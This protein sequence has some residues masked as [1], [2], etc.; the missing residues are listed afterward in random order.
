MEILK[1]E[2]GTKFWNERIH[3]KYRNTYEDKCLYNRPCEDFVVCC[4]I[5]VAV[6]TETTPVAKLLLLNSSDAF[7][8]GIQRM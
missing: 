2:L 3:L 7:A 1:I 5:C 6:K 4:I 8:D